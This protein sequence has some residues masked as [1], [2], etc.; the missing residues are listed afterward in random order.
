[1]LDFDE[2]LV[3]AFER[4]AA[5]SPL[6]IA[7]GSEFC[8]TTYKELNET[9]N[10]LA[11]GLAAYGSEFESRAAILMSHDAPMV[12]A[13]LGVL[14]TGQT[15]VALDPGDPLSHLR[16]LA[17]DAEPTLIITDAQNHSLATALVRADCRILDFEAA[18]A[19]GSAEN[20]FI[21]I[22][23]QRT[24]FLTFTSGT[25]GRPK[26]V[27]RPHLQLLKS[28]AVYSEA[29][30]STE[31]DRIPLFSSVSTGQSWNTICWSLLNGAMLCPFRVR[32][33]GI[34]GLADWIID[35]K[36]TIYS[37]STSI[38]RSLVKTIDDR[39]VFSTV[40]AV[41]LASEAVTAEDFKA[42]RKHF[43]ACS[44]LVH[45]LTCSESSPIAWSRWTQNAKL[46]ERALP[47]G[48]CARDM[49]VSL[50][51]DDGQPVA[52]GEVGEIVVKSR[53]L[54]NGY[55]RDSELTAER[56]SADLDGN[57][58][59]QLRTGDQGR[60]NADGLLEF[61]GR[62]DERIKIRGNRIEPLDIER[63]FEGLAGIDRVAVV[64]VARDNHEPVLV[65]FVVNK[66]E[67]SW[68]VPRLRHAV[69]AKLPFHM[70]PSRIVFLER[71]PYN[72]GNKIDREA[73]R[74]YSFPIRNTTKNEK[75]QTETEMLLAD[76]WAEIFD[77]P[78]IDRNDDFFDLGGDSLSGA[79]VAARIHAALE[80]E[81]TLGEI[82]DHP[83]V[84]ALAALI[85]DCR[86]TG[87]AGRPP[88]VC[89]PREASM[90]VSFSQ[91]LSWNHQRKNQLIRIL[92]I[93][94]PLDIGNLKH[95]LSYLVDRHEVLRT[96]FGFVDG[97]LAQIIHPC[98]PL[99]FSFIDLVGADDPEGQ[100]DSIFR[101]EDSQDINLETLPIMR[102]VL[103]R[104][105][106]E[107]YRLARIF[108]HI[109]MDGTSSHILNTELAIL[110]EARLQGTEPP[111]PRVPPLQYADYAAWQRQVMRPNSPY[112]NAVMRWWKSVIP[113]EPPTIRLP[114][115]RLTPRAGLDPS[116]GVLQWK[117][118]ER[119][120]KRLD[121]F[122]RKV[123][124]TH[125][126][127]RFAAFAALVADVTGNST[128]VIGTNF[129]GRNRVDPQNILGPFVNVTP[130]V[131]CYDPTK[132]FL[133]WLQIVR[134][135]V[136]ETGKHSEVS[137]EE[138]KQQLRSER[139]ELPE[140]QIIFAMSADHSDQHFGS[141]AVSDEFYSVGS[142]PWG[143]IVQIDERKPENCRVNFD[144]HV[145]DRN[146]MRMLLDRYLRL[147]EAA[148]RE[149]ELSIGRLLAMIGGRPLRWTCANYAAPVY[150][151][152]TEFY[153]SSP[154]LKLCW[155]PIRRWV[156]S[157]G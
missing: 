108:S 70:V 96:T 115:R 48:H 100:A 49:D 64:A 67:A 40:R 109:I 113:T 54:A 16:V 71:L 118:E 4:V 156:L 119:T 129:V 123:G 30:Q 154:L 66:S 76:I 131:F 47:V 133:E 17:E 102:H 88:I 117:L 75:P 128:I 46:P 135:R 14:K 29:L 35:R 51:G 79:I 53:Y 62:K 6:R 146:G 13:A 153:A 32:T 38:F 80:V 138:V 8:Q 39:L 148:A 36:L 84:L 90:P 25:T 95:C 112:F 142:M 105:A 55:W 74:Q 68:T 139:I 60:I 15:V 143:C 20:P 23:P 94:G 85:D 58:T 43:P 83:T 87:T 28:A 57:G 98:A 24:A 78:D 44:V 37:S 41:R 10:R 45:G 101:K 59:R 122:A 73:L 104:T 18:T 124:A 77:R 114:F 82:A 11:H 126:T 145:Y 7:V 144:A 97:R 132:T 3:A 86:R 12:A 150:E 136:F 61:C 157:R 116:E 141:L 134:D 33:R 152:V 69:R 137:Y 22:S 121:Q 110:Y 27:M 72:R 26:G 89:V 111:L 93:S 5:T 120:A 92:R 65:A 63:A 50:L 2:S 21:S 91:E 19:T 9:A 99:D 106:H 1:M 151:F 34:G 130:V 107:N 81:L 155:R 140:I 31:D 52:R 149:P 42:C 125:F 103:I 56:F 147:L 127:V